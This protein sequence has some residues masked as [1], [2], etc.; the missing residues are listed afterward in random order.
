MECKASAPRLSPTVSPQ[1]GS[2]GGLAPKR[3]KWCRG[4]PVP[5]AQA[6]RGEGVR[7][8]DGSPPRRRRASRT[9]T[10]ARG[11]HRPLP[12][13][14]PVRRWCAC[15]SAVALHGGTHGDGDSGGW[16]Q[17]GEGGGAAGRRRGIGWMAP[18]PRQHR[19][20]PPPSLVFALRGGESSP[21]VGEAAAAATAVTATPAA[22]AAAAA[23]TAAVASGVVSGRSGGLW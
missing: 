10:P 9:A 22:V 12:L 2:G 7:G 3:P 11:G 6:E 15:G 13:P 5:L 14:A 20:V 4:R 19:T 23:A 18:A 16:R 8:V 1:R 21:L 17:G